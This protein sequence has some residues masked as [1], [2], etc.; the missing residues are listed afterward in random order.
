MRKML[1]IA[2]TIYV[3]NIII[4]FST[5]NNNREDAEVNNRLQPSQTPLNKE[6]PALSGNSFEHDLHRPC[7]FDRIS[8]WDP[9]VTNMFS[10]DKFV[11]ENVPR[12]EKDSN[13]ENALKIKPGECFNVIGKKVYPHPLF[14]ESGQFS[15]VMSGKELSVL[16][17]NEQKLIA[18]FF[19]NPNVL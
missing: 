3:V 14:I 18:V 19:R 16:Y 10:M 1:V 4:I 6:R 13:E 5:S 11:D 15:C 9:V 8:S 2:T 12:C 7:V 17:N